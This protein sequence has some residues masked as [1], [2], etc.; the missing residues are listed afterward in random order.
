ML[1]FISLKVILLVFISLSPSC[2]P[3]EEKKDEPSTETDPGGGGGGS[4]PMT[5][6][7]NF[8]IIF[9]TTTEVDGT[10][11]S[12][13]TGS[14]L[15]SFD[16]LCETEKIQ[17]G[18]GGTFK[19]L[20]GTGQ[21]RP[22]GTDWILR[23]G[24]EY[25]RE[26]LTTVIDIAENNVTAGGVIFPFVD[27]PM[28][29]TINSIEKIA[30]TGFKNDWTHDSTNCS[31]WT[32][33]DFDNTSATQGT[34]G[35][36]SVNDE[37]VDLGYTSYQGGP[38]LHNGDA[39]GVSLRCNQKHPIYCVQTKQLPPPG[40]TKKIFISTAVRGDAGFAAFDAQ[41]ETDR[42]A[43]GLTGTYKAVV[44]GRSPNTGTVLRQVCSAADCTGAT[45]MEQSVDWPLQ[46]N[47]Q[48]KLTDNVTYIGMTNA[49]GFFQGEF[50][51]PMGSGNFWTGLTNTWVTEANFQMCNGW[52]EPTFN[53]IHG[54]HGRSINF[55]NAAIVCTNSF[56]VI[57][58]EQ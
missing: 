33:N 5:T 6:Q 45:G 48:Y 43:N 27:S 32:R 37:L 16:A 31:D 57:C 7:G 58:A 11:A 2:A 26:D 35:K 9:V 51:E 17:K 24:K 38:L 8:R 3:E 34:Y 46:A 20:I 15:S 28:T 29:N 41:C 52:S 19:A 40:T 4:N 44:A 50:E 53:G 22:N 10:G 42:V 39:T 30:W 56:G 12:T 21:R 47:M 1:K 23:A 13:G 18:F 25:R 54:V 36:S 14:G 49:H 55:S